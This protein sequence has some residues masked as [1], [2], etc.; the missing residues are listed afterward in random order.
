MGATSGASGTLD[1]SIVG[2]GGLTALPA[3]AVEVENAG[4]GANA[5]ITVNLTGVAGKTTYMTGLQITA[6]GATAAGAVTAT[7]FLAGSAITLNF[8]IAVPA[9]ASVGVTPLI[10]TFPNAISAGGQNQVIQTILPAL[11]AG[12]L[13]A[14]VNVT[15]YRL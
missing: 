3:G 8:V 15:G 4:T 11:G 1:V 14:A 5:Q 9:G 2:N 12:N 13:L 7:V 6:T 10:V